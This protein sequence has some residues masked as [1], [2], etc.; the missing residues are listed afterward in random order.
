M[1]ERRNDTAAE[2]AAQELVI[3]RV[4]DAAVETVWKAWTD[5][6]H[7]IRWWG[8]KDFTAPFARIDLRVGGKYLFCMRGAGPDGVIRDYWSTGEYREIDRPKKLRMTDCF[9]DEKGNVVPAA[10][11]GM[12]GDMALEMMITVTFEE[13]SG[14]TKM[15]LRQAG[16]P[17]GEHFEGAT[18][19]WNTMLDKLAEFVK[20]A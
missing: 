9:A 2:T 20:E 16:L 8:P 11:Y 18:V 6:E 15:T 1:A 14:K 19:G 10:Y 4:F 12:E 3:T 7:A 17:A 5:A 13:L